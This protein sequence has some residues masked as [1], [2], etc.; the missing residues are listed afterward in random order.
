MDGKFVTT[1]PRHK[2]LKRDLVKG[3]V[4]DMNA[5]GAAIEAL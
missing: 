2:H 3:I 5:H 1:I 4:D